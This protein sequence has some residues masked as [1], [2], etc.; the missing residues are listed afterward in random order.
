MRARI[1]WYLEVD[2]DGVDVFDAKNRAETSLNLDGTILVSTHGNKTYTGEVT[3]FSL[4]YIHET[5]ENT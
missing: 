4:L 3:K 5:K 2:M 1:G